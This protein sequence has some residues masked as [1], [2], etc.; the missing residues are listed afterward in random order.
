VVGAASYSV[1]PV[2]VMPP[3]QAFFSAATPVPVED[4][5]GRVSAEL[6]AP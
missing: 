4:A 3:R 2:T 5:V 1:D 6:I